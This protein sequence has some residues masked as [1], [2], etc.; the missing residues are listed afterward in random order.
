MVA[1]AKKKDVSGELLAKR[2]CGTCHHWERFPDGKQRAGQ[3]VHGECWL[4]PPVVLD[5]DENG[6]VLQASPLRRFR[7]RCGQHSPKVN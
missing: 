4:M 5:V 1:A 7:E 6:D 2:V 3:D